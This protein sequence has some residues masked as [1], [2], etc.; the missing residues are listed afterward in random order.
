MKAYGIK[1]KGAYQP[2]QTGDEMASVKL[3]VWE[4]EAVKHSVHFCLSHDAIAT[5]SG[6][7]LADILDTASSITVRIKGGK[8]KVDVTKDDEL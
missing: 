1:E 8:P 5:V 2:Q 7:K 3:T 4:L 6:R